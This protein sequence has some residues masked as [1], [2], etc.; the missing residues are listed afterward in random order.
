MTMY[1]FTDLP[2]DDLILMK[3]NYGQEHALTQKRLAESCGGSVRAVQDAL[4][5]MKR[6]GRPIC[7]GNAGVW[8]SDSADELR[9]MYRRDRARAIRQ[10]VNNRGRL[11]AIA[12]LEGYHQEVLFG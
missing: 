7:T 10:M 2:L 11:K 1:E 8:L 12:A 6:A 3:L 9:Q 4:E 5:G